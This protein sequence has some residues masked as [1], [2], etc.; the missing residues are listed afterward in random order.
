[1]ATSVEEAGMARFRVLYIDDEPDICEIVAL[2]LGLDPSLW[3]HSCG[4]G[5]EALATAAEWRPDIILCDV[6]MPAMDGPA[7]LARLRQHPQTAGTPFIFMTSRAQ[8][9]E[10]A[11]F[12][13]LGANGLIVKPFNPMT[14]ADSVLS[15]LRPAARTAA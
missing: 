9:R 12:K 13:S 11:H 2:A 7:T 6:V 1:L 14:L 4:S 5:K 15:Y 8:A 10:I 3:V